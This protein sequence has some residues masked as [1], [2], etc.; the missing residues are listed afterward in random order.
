MATPPFLNEDP[1][2]LDK[3]IFE[4]KST[5]TEGRRPRHERF[6]ALSPIARPGCRQIIAQVGKGFTG[7]LGL[8]MWPTVDHTQAIRESISLM[9][10]ATAG[11]KY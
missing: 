8:E 5:S 2:G 1:D 9:A 4:P 7:F 6:H 11:R 10:E 3:R